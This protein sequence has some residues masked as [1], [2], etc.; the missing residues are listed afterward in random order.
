MEN[1]GGDPPPRPP[2]RLPLL[3]VSVV[4]NDL[5]DLLPSSLDAA[6]T[7]D[8]CRGWLLSL[9]GRG[10]L[11][12]S[13]CVVPVVVAFAVPR[14]VLP[15]AVPTVERGHDR[16]AAAVEPRSSSRAAGHSRRGGCR[17]RGG[18]SPW[19][20]PA[21]RLWGWGG[22]PAGHWAEPPCSAAAAVDAVGTPG[23][24]RRQRRPLWPPPLPAG[25]P[26]SRIGSWPCPCCRVRTCSSGPFSQLS[27][28]QHG[29]ITLVQSIGVI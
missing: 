24:G 2:Q 13:R 16:E 5:R 18:G 28:S 4:L 3:R 12:T 25:S 19:L 11:T 22:R 21:A 26:T 15:P 1:G 23:V 9:V 7:A 17:L 10:V 27:D 6:A 20:V 14:T 29:R 8:H